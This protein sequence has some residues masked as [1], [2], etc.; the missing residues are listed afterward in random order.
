MDYLFF[1]KE[2]QIWTINKNR[3]KE[4]KYEFLKVTPLERHL[5]ILH[6]DGMDLINISIKFLNASCNKKMC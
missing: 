3:T 5:D 1:I 6:I 4:Y 2:D